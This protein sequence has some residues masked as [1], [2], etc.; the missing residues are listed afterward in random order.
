MR[1]FN[2]VRT[3]VA[4][5]GQGTISFGSA[6][7]DFLTPL[8]AGAVDGDET[9][10]VLEEGSNFEISRGVIGASATTVTRAAVLISKIDGTVG[11]AR[12]ELAG[13]AVVHF[14][15][16]AEDINDLVADAGTHKRMADVTKTENYTLTSSDAGQM[17]VFNTATAIS[18]FLPALSTTDG[19][20]LFVKCIG[21]GALT[22]DPS[23]SEQ[24]EGAAI[25]TLTMG[26]AA[27]IWPDEGKAAWRAVLSYP[28]S[29][30]VPA[31]GIITDP[32]ISTTSKLH[33]RINDLPSVK[34]FLAK[35]DGVQDD[36]ACL[37]AA[38]D[39]NRVV[40]IPP[41]RYRITKPLIV[42]G[43]RNRNN[44]FI[45]TSITSYWP[46]TS[47][48]GGPDWSS[49]LLES[50]IWYDR[51]AHASKIAT[52]ASSVAISG[53]ARSF[54]VQAGK[55]FATTDVVRI[56]YTSSPTLS[57][58][59]GTVTAYN[60]G[61]GQLDV[62]V[63][64][65]AGA[66]ATGTSTTSLTIGA[67]AK[68]LTTQTDR[69]FTAGQEV[70]L[71]DQS[72]PTTNY[73]TGTVTS[74][75]SGTGALVVDITSV[76]GSGSFDDWAIEARSFLS[77]WAIEAVNM[78]EATSA[79]SVAIGT[80]A[81]SFTVQTD[82][83]FTAG[84]Q[85]TVRRTAAPT[86]NYMYGTITSYVPATGALVVDVVG[87]GGAGTLA[88]WTIEAPSAVIFA[89]PDHPTIAPIRSFE[90]SI[91]N[92]TLLNVGLDGNF[93]AHYGIFTSRM[94]GAQW[95]NVHAARTR[96]D[97]FNI[98]G[99]FNGE[100]RRL[101]SNNQIGRGISIGAARVD[102]GWVSEAACNAVR[103][104]DIAA[105]G[106]G[107]N[108]LFNEATAAQMREGCGIYFSPHR[109][110]LIDGW[111]S[112]ANDGAG[113]VFEPNDTSNVVRNGY[114]ELNNNSNMTGIGTAVATGRATGQN[115]LIVVGSASNGSYASKVS[116]LFCGGGKITL[117]GKPPT[118]RYRD[119][120]TL[121]GISSVT[122]VKAA[123]GWV[124]RAV[125]NSEELLDNVS[126]QRP[127]ND[128]TWSPTVRGSGTAGVNTYSVAQGTL[129]MRPDGWAEVHLRI[130]GATK[131]G[132]MAGNLEIPFPTP[133]SGAGPLSALGVGPVRFSFAVGEFVVSGNIT[134]LAEAASGNAFISLMKNAG[135]GSSA[136]MQA[137]DWLGTG[138]I[139]ISGMVRY[140]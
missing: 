30:F 28:P 65:L 24:I 15:Q 83:A 79:S 41:G 86:T 5:T 80:G 62:N 133:P 112:E 17:V 52:S 102:L 109:G 39:S 64:M 54:I 11:T 35:G 91:L 136:L 139:D 63:T 97:G 27:M 115:S 49:G 71:R 23:A 42:R 12:M 13:T 40:L 90:N 96:R 50:W 85:I 98:N 59:E 125:D 124:Y 104:R 111:Q 14:I 7:S 75:A 140:A 2:R 58:M 6:S 36:T 95:Q 51:P 8:Q 60:S 100:F 105:L 137:A 106:C 88:D 69:G 26:M 47:Q 118:P 67:G 25:L 99:A 123:T 94:Q 1:F 135:A 92:L 110:C 61:T 37:Q 56:K 10:F 121:D 108:G 70:F 120:F 119:A 130:V 74:Y 78:L 129:N 21:T 81:K 45:G 43:T 89:A 76:A 19:E 114:T 84:E 131:D 126:G 134:P 44:G 113:L 77:G 103:F 16:S 57:W 107:L 127:I 138:R 33:N 122:G 9:T 38:L 20:A 46:V 53:G 32:M 4:T 93:K 3:T 22:V 116:K 132:N 66:A 34:D 101:V 29:A 31:D 82:K 72:A 18:A 117:T 73:M 128:L 87:V 68:P 55:S 48:P